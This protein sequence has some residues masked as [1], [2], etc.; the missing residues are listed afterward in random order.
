MEIM[1]QR[2][3]RRL[4]QLRTKKLGAWN[5]MFGRSDGSLVLAEEICRWQT[6]LIEIWSS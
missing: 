5:V 1:R 6:V 4:M 2:I 3:G